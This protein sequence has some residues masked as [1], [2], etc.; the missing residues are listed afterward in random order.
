MK[1]IAFSD[2]L[3]L[4]RKE[5]GEFI[6][7]EETWPYQLKKLLSKSNQEAE[8][9][10]AG[11]RARTV[12]SLI[13]PDFHECIQLLEPDVVILQ[14]GIVDATPRI[15]SRKEKIIMNSTFFPKK[16]RD[17]I[18]RNRKKNKA[19][20]TNRD[21]LKKVYTKPSLFISCLELF[22]QRISGLEL[23][24][25]IIPIL[26]NHRI[27]S[28]HSPRF[29]ENIELYNQLLHSFAKKHK[30]LWLSLRDDWYSKDVY[31]CKDG[32]HLNALGNR[33]LAEQISKTI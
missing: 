12:E 20:I 19:E 2:S 6:K 17:Y 14:M 10:N 16:I 9:I 21:P 32:Y 7:W 1:I 23:K 26:A 3:S 25:V 24:V 28:I 5:A 27:K 8:I 13:G 30:H 33:L 18:I 11:K 22:N 29:V 4:P 31:Y 15:V